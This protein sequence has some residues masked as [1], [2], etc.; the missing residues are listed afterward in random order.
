[1]HTSDRMAP[2]KAFLHLLVAAL[3]CSPVALAQTNSS[4]Y[5]RVLLPV[6]VAR[7][8]LGAFGAVWM[9]N[10]VIRNDSAKPVTI[11]E[12]ECAHFCTCVGFE[13]EMGK[14][15]EPGAV[16][17]AGVSPNPA[18]VANVG[19]FVFIERKAA[20]D[21]SMNL[22]IR[23]L[24]RSP[25]SFGTEVPIVRERDAFEGV[26]RLL[27]VPITASARQHLRM[28]AF[29]SV[30]GEGVLRVRIFEANGDHLLHESIVQLNP[31]V[32][33]RVNTASERFGYPAYAELSDLRKLVPSDFEDDVRVEVTSLTPG[34]RYWAMVSVTHNET[35]QI[36]LV[37]PQ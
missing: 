16:F 22:R 34:L 10:L 12:F 17:P 6:V 19:L 29:S 31:S 2:R 11:F 28:F 20:T 3:S 8:R 36:T 23:E 7:P 9:T 18:D 26:V 33:R 27:A 35:Q 15:V 24:T 25:S 30:T 4:D 13:C 32:G 21:V 37:S 1:M 14:P 5:E